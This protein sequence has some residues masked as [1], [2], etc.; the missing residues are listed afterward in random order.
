MT[1]IDHQID[2]FNR[3]ASDL[4]QLPD[5]L[6]TRAATQMVVEPM[7]GVTATYIVQTMRQHGVGD[8]IFLQVMSAEAGLIRVAIPPR[9]A[10]T[11]ARQR[12]ALDVKSQRQ[13]TVV[14]QKLGRDQAAKR[15]AA[16]VVP[17]GGKPHHHTKARA[18]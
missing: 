8:T 5:V 9:V 11:I 10:N 13:A 7:V 6:K 3:K 15:K 12:A 14:R 18:S 2:P 17:F 1:D 4:V 16:G